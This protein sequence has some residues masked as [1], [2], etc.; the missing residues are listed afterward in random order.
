MYGV[1]KICNIYIFFRAKS[2]DVNSHKPSWDLCYDYA[3]LVLLL[4]NRYH[5]QGVSWRA[6]KATQ[7]TEKR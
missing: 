3:G 1:W 6:Q 2:T 4:S 7:N 5:P